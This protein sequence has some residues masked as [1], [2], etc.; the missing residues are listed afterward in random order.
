MADRSASRLQKMN[1]AS[2]RGIII[3]SPTMSLQDMILERSDVY[4]SVSHLDSFNHSN[5][6]N[7]AD[8]IAN[9][10]NMYRIRPPYRLV[11][12]EPGDRSCHWRPN[13]LCIYKG[14]LAAGVRFPFHPFIPELL[15]DVGINPCQLP[16]NAWRLI[17]CF[18]VL[19]LKNNFPLS[20]ALFR[21]IFQFKNS[22][23]KT[24]GW[25]YINHRPTTPPIFHPKSIPDN[26][27]KWRN[28]FMYF[29]WDGGNWGTLFQSSFSK[30]SDGSPGD[31]VL[32]EEEAFA[33]AELTK[34]NYATMAW[35][36]LDEFLLK[37][38]ELS[39][40]SEK[41]AEFINKQNE[42]EGGQ[43]ARIKRACLKDPR[44]IEKGPSIL[45]PHVAE[46]DEVEGST[47]S[48]VWRPNWGI[49]KK[50]TIVGVSAHAV[51]WSHHSLTPCDY[52][53]FVSN[54][55]LEGA[56]CAGAQAFAAANAN[57][58]GALFQ[59]KAWRSSSEANKAEYDQAQ[60]EVGSL[61][62][63]LDRR[64]KELLEAQAE[65]VEL[66]KGK[67]RIID[68]YFDSAE[69]QEI[70]TQHDDL[71]FPVQFT[72]G[73]DEALAEVSRRIPGSLTISDFPSPHA[74]NQLEKALAGVDDMD[75]DDMI[76]NPEHASQPGEEL[77]ESSSGE[78]ESGEEEE[79]SGEEE[80]GEEEASEDEQGGDGAQ[81]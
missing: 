46:V 18:I 33:Y 24:L 81:P 45:R 1:Q 78:E 41:A 38:L 22:S 17:M 48:S 72:Q 63:S 23:S 58:Q 27:P 51:E 11:L 52:K 68:E 53:D 26:N 8:A 59:A 56:E 44:L 80:S 60:V 9:Y 36:L 79:D 37:S 35:E 31:I 34:D 50:D 65:L 19:C 13:A 29:V 7:D 10:K 57:F 28:E 66:R 47:K 70:I 39:R 2:K 16:P 76:L 73:W 43:T 12:A 3:R 25:V 67:D 6:F 20:V 71:L 54:S 4:P 61:K 21:R 49:R 30:V 64:D 15:A 75:E 74:P 14:V 32:T 69:Y 40:V 77:E 62:A 5:R 42:L 55:T